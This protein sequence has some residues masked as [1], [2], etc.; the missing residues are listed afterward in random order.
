MNDPSQILVT[1]SPVSGAKVKYICDSQNRRVRELNM[2]TGIM[3]TIAGTG[4][5]SY[6]TGPATE[7]NLSWPTGICQSPEGDLFISDAGNRTIMK[8]MFL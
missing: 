1:R 2:D 5:T 6:C 3:T 7:S 8:L 4:E